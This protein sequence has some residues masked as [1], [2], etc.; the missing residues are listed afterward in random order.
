MYVSVCDA[1]KPHPFS[2]RILNFLAKYRQS[3]KT[4]LILK[5]GEEKHRNKQVTVGEIFKQ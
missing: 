3:I 2:S 1:E 5:K 4:E